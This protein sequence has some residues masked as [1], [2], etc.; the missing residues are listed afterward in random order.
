M[1]SLGPS[2]QHVI[3]S[4][5][6]V[7]VA[8][9]RRLRSRVHTLSPRSSAAHMLSAARLLRALHRRGA[10]A[11]CVQLALRA[12]APASRRGVQG[13]AYA[14]FDSSAARDA[15]P[16]AFRT[17]W[18]EAWE[19]RT[20]GVRLTA[21]ARAG[22][23]SLPL[24]ASLTCGCSQERELHELQVALALEGEGDDAFGDLMGARTRIS[25]FV[26][27]R[28]RALGEAEAAAAFER[29]DALSR[30]E[31]AA[32]VDAADVLSQRRLLQLGFL[33]AHQRAARA[34]AAAETPPLAGL[35]TEVRGA[36]GAARC[37]V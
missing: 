30:A 4:P 14:A 31:R 8:S 12:A 11:E 35:L 17:R 9:Q 21:Q 29:Y 28:L 16:Q 27:A 25:A 5:L 1:S 19:R 33:N 23:A 22:L 13:R 3:A 18:R 6:V 26:A 7:P 2:A 24:A 10:G 36:R 20:H 15:A 37:V 34:A 32:A